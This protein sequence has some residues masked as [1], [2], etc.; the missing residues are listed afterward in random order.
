MQSIPKQKK[1]WEFKASADDVGELYIYGDI[2]SWKW[3][4]E[5]TTANSFKDDLKALGEIKTLNL[6]INSLGG[7]VFQAQAIYS[8]LKRH[9][10]QKNVYVDGVAAS[11]ASMIAMAGD[12][13]SMPANAMMMIHWPW[14]FAYGN[15][16]EFRKMADDLDK[17]GQ[18]TVAAYM[19]KLDGKTAEEKLSE[20]LDDETWLTAQ[21]CFDYGFCDELL[22][23]KKIAASV[24]TELFAHY[25]NVPEEIKEILEKVNDHDKGECRLDKDRREKLVKEC[26][27]DDE[28][29]NLILGVI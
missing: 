28:T 10:A 21:E 16:K 17:I 25:K 6:Y 27:Q 2:V 13:V 19:A 26:R 1:F 8:I 15:A 3:D 22:E 20:L 7:S 4:D 23:E 18:S 12:K 9:S 11:A 29:I 14:T 5:D 24:S